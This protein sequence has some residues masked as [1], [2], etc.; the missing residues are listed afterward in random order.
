M[1]HQMDYKVVTLETLNGGAVKDLFDVALD[2]LL[3]NIGDEN[4]KADASRE[5]RIVVSVKPDKQ[6]ATAVSKVAVTTK[7]APVNPHESFVVLSSD[8]SRVMAYTTDPKQNELGLGEAD[9]KVT[10]FPAAAGGGK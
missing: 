3:E 5:I 6:R 7:L 9:G 2:K 1:E 8:G 4:T 10:P